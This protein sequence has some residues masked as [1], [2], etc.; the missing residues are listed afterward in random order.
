MIKVH[1]CTRTIVHEC[2][3]IIMHTSNP[4]SLMFD[5]TKMR[6]GCLGIHFCKFSSGPLKLY[7][8]GPLIQAFKRS[9]LRATLFSGAHVGACDACLCLRLDRW[10][11]VRKRCLCMDHI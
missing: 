11:S 2:A 4:T 3:M 5:T 1:E 8:G 6:A 10:D 9:P 7:V